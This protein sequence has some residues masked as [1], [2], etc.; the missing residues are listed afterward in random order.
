MLVK[1]IINPRCKIGWENFVFFQPINLLAD[2]IKTRTNSTRYLKCPA[3]QDYYK[4]TFI[5]K[6]PVDIKLNINKDGENFHI[7]SPNNTQE[8]FDRFIH[9]RHDENKLYLTLSIQIQYVFISKDSVMVE[10]LPTNFHN[11]SFR[12]NI[13]LIGG[14]FD[15]SKWYRP[16]DFT[17]E[18]IDGCNTIDIKRGDPLMYVRFNTNNKVKLEEQEYNEE[19]I[20]TVNACLDTKY[21]KPNNTMQE[22]YNIAEKVIN[23]IKNKLFKGCP[24]KKL[25]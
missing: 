20:Q 22:N 17:F 8:F 6:S 9:V 16:V 18:V 23:K 3:F 4:N 1:Y 10:V 19:L 24:F 21:Y 15:I 14:T 25:W 2:L 12:G 7:N 5:I 13:N 11:T